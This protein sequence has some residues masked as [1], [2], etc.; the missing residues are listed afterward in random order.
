MNQKIIEIIQEGEN[1][2]VEFKA[3]FNDEVIVS[4]CAFANAK[5]GTVYVGVE[6]N[7]KVK[8][9]TLS[10]ESIS[11]W[12]NEIKTKTI[13]VLIPDIEVLEIDTLTIVSLHT[14]E[15]PVKPVSSR[16]KYYK[17]IKNS[18]HQ[19][20]VSE[21][22]DMHINSLNKSWDSYPN[23]RRNLDDISIE[24]VNNCIEKIK[25]R[26]ITI[27]ETPLTFLQ[28]YDLIRD[29]KLT[30]AAFLLFKSEK[31]IDTTIELG[32]FQDLITIKDTS[33]SQSDV[34]T[35]VEEVM[36]FVKKH[37]FV[38][39]LL[40][41]EAENK[42][43]WQYPIEAIREIVLN[44]IVHR[45][46]RSNSD[47]V[48]KIFD[49]KIE[50]YNPGKLPDGITIEDLIQNNY[51]STPRNILI[52]ECFKN[53][54]LIEKYGSG[55]G[56]ILDYFKK[57]N[58]PLPDFRMVGNGFQV[59]I[60]SNENINENDTEN[61]AEYVSVKP[62]VKYIRKPTEKPTDK[63]TDKPTEKLSKNQQKIIQLLIQNQKITSNEI[64]LNIGIRADS[65]RDNL[66]KLKSL[67]KIRRIGPDKGGYWEVI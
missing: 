35:Q 20:L 63:P 21:V 55:F 58:L 29:D 2:R 31:T 9:V 54:G 52:A 59:T 43:V 22:A 46:Y 28:K 42:Q 57:A 37:I 26:G 25:N 40:T 30:N 11:Q 33:R 36:D 27:Q 3:S 48:V 12:I 16:G 56:R 23:T 10:K 14:Q 41:G 44:M 62:I 65:V 34:L 64:A 4:L 13:P 61:I 51:K 1:E 17:R 47:S 8:G 5:G 53:M 66:L 24:K 39:L 7:G 18:N 67:G 6:D 50:F 15:Y 32:R 45:E 60:Y 49:N 19:L 38:S